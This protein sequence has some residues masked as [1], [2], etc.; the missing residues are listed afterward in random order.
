MEKSRHEKRKEDTIAQESDHHNHFNLDRA[1]IG[2][3]MTGRRILIE[4][5]NLK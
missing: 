2:Q 1:L 5:F 3:E 4:W